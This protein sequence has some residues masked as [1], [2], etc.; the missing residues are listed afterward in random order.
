M[1]KS[2]MGYI[3]PK[4]IQ[5]ILRGETP[6]ISVSMYVDEVSENLKPGDT[7]EDADGNKWKINKYGDKIRESV[8]QEARMPWFCPKCGLIMSKRLDDK[9]YWSQGMCF[10][11][12][13]KR[14]QKM[15]IEGTFEAFQKKYIN[16]R[17]IG[18]L[19]DAKIEIKKY[20]GDLS[21]IKN[22]V[23]EDGTLEEWT[24]SSDKVREFLE[25]EV[26]EIEES[27]IKLGTKHSEKSKKKM[28]ES[29]QGQI[30][31]NKGR[32]NLMENK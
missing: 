5:A 10:E 15:G 20:L 17:K 9:M 13:L 30:P 27:L 31:W 23:N 18:F 8:M 4:R 21:N 3:Y 12:V 6:K 26:I 7:W 25:N 19:K 2:P 24:G 29:H 14:D 11:C 28:S 22:F 16:D 32:S 1:S